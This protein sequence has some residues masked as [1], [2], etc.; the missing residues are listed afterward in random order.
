MRRCS[1]LIIDPLN[2]EIVWPKQTGFKGL[3]PGL[4]A[5]QVGDYFYNLNSNENEKAKNES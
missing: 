5:K 1:E 3:V 2:I 4:R